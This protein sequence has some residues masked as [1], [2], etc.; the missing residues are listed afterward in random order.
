MAIKVERSE[1]A[2][3]NSPRGLAR[4]LLAQLPNLSFPVPID[5]IALACD[6]TEIKPLAAASF[7]GMLITAD[8]KTD[9]VIF[10]SKRNGTRR[11]RFTVGHELG[12]FLNAWHVPPEGG[13]QCTSEHMLYSDR[14]QTN[15]RMQME[16]E[17]NTFAAEVLM[18]QRLFLDQLQKAGAHP[19]VSAVLKVADDFLVS[20]LAAARRVVGLR[21]DSAAILSRDGTIEQIYRG[22]DFPF[23]SLKKGQSVPAG[24][25]SR[26]H[27]GPAGS[28]SGLEETDPATWTS[29]NTR[30]GLQ[31]LEQVLLQREGYRLT[32][33][34]LD[35]SECVEDDDDDEA[36]WVREQSTWNPTFHRS[37]RK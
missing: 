7:D 32:M 4:A 20:K 15:D 19:T 36:G 11:W 35:E 17:A 18:P 31:F 14:R 6:I 24:C 30:K 28:L 8:A 34:L 21:R 25:V 1:L 33:L 23:I 10:A 26:Q 3:D 12:H 2:D 22:E 5:E 27:S 16:A 29:R 13:F 37:R 9:G